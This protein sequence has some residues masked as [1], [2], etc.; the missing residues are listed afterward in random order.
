MPVVQ[1]GFFGVFGV[2]QSW[3]TEASFAVDLSSKFFF[4]GWSCLQQLWPTMV[5]RKWLH[6]GNKESD[7]SADPDDDGDNEDDPESD[8]DYEE[9]ESIYCNLSN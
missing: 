9:G 6:I 1:V 3:E 7:Y 2:Y 5:M 4:F 8:S